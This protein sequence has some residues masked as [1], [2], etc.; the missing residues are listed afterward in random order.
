MARK[1]HARVV[2]Q[3][4]ADARLLDERGPTIERIRRTSGFDIG[5]TAVSSIDPNRIFA[6]DGNFS[7]MAKTENQVFHRQRYR[8]AVEKLGEERG[9]VLEWMVCREYQ[10][11]KIGYSLGWQNK[12]QAIA[13]ATQTSRSGLNVLC[14][15]W[16]IDRWS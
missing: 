13:A 2:G 15:L 4:V 11:E 8:D 10:L 14:E 3:H 9:R 12:S 1:Q 6:T 5:D 7:G 16:G